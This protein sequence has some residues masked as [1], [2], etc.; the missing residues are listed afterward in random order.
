MRRGQGHICI[1]AGCSICQAA[2]ST[3]N[4]LPSTDL[5]EIE[6]LALMDGVTGLYNVRAFQKKLRYELKRSRR[7]KRPI[8]LAMIGIDG[9][10]NISAE[11]GELASATVLRSIAD[12]LQTT[13]RDVD[14]AGKYSSAWFAVLFPETNASGAMKIAERIRANIESC[15]LSHNWNNFKLTASIGVS[16]FPAQAKDVDM[17]FAQTIQALELSIHRGGNRVCVS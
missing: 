13:I 9:F 8:A 2:Q 14:V 5:S 17:L 4:K 12:V 1:G 10:N 11:Y 6:R 16:S 15:P 3:V 7:Y